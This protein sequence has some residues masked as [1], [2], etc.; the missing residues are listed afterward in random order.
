MGPAAIRR[1]AIAIYNLKLMIPRLCHLR[2]GGEEEE[3]K[4]E[5]GLFLIEKRLRERALCWGEEG[6]GEETQ[7]KVLDVSYFANKKPQT[8]DRK[9]RE[10][11]T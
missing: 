5:H 11:T 8:H 7:E 1:G 3:G 10:S 6:M 2:V 4:K 9:K